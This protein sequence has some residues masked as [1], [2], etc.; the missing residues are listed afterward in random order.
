MALVPP[1][2]VADEVERTDQEIRALRSVEPVAGPVPVQQN[3]HLAPTD[4]VGGRGRV[5]G[6]VDRGG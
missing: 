5:V 4:R 1:G 6:R 3:A 2:F